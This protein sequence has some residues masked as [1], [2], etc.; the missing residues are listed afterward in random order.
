[1]LAQSMALGL[2]ASD[3]RDFSSVLWLLVGAFVLHEAEEWNITAFERRNFVDLPPQV[4][5]ENGRAWLVFICVVAAGWCAAAT[6][7]GS[8]KLA[9][10]VFLPAVGL[11]VANALQ[12]VFW[13]IYFK[14]YA[15]GVVSAVLLLL[16]LAIYVAA[17]AGLRDLVPLWYLLGLALM[18][19]VIVG[20]TV[21]SR[22]R[23]TAPIRAIYAVG[24]WIL[25]LARMHSGR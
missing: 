17:R 21:R 14:E 8:P 25:R 1:M 19:A 10:F 7:P 24:A 9:A 18:I 3:E 20:N 12:H 11:A 22:R 5:E 16:P 13:A 6:L 4:T 15:P 2:T 23:M